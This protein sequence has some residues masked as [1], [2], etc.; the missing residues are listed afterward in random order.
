MLSNSNSSGFLTSPSSS[1]GK[2]AYI[3]DDENQTPSTNNQSPTIGLFEPGPNGNLFGQVT[4]LDLFPYIINNVLSPLV[5][6][7]IVEGNLVSGI[8]SLWRGVYEGGATQSPSVPTPP[9]A[10]PQAPQK[11]YVVDIAVA[12]EVATTPKAK[13]PRRRRTRGSTTTTT[14]TTE[15]SSTTTAKG[16]L[17]EGGVE[18]TTTTS[19]SKYRLVH[20]TRT[21]AS[22][23]TSQ[24]PLN[25]EDNQDDEDETL[26][27]NKLS[28]L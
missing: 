12:E 1:S 9:K 8:S 21:P 11:Q 6:R 19:K 4:N 18:S 28:H 2:K 17:T 27:F 20:R 10:A 14:T 25:F 26:I 24:K 23:T 3:Q 15:K 13:P 7:V 5:Q 16:D 22:S